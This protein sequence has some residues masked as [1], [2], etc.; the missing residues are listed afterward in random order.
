MPPEKNA[1]NTP[2]CAGTRRESPDPFID[3][4]NRKQETRKIFPLP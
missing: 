1:P 4:K 2:E 3:D